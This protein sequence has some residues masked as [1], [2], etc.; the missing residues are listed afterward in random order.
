MPDKTISN[1]IRYYYN[2][3]KTRNKPSQ[4]DRKQSFPE[5]NVENKTGSRLTVS[6]N[7][8]TTHQ[9]LLSS[10]SPS[11]PQAAAPQNLDSDDD[12]IVIENGKHF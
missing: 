11:S 8:S 9:K 3:K 4:I 10:R 5:N 12:I 2:W 7:S 6:G 1:L